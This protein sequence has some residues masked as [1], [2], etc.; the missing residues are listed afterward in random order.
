MEKDA[1]FE[2]KF[3]IVILAKA[4]I[5]GET[6]TGSRGKNPDSASSAE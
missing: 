6:P 5:Q 2:I 4:G 1:K 3:E